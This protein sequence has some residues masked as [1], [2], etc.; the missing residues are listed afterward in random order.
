DSATECER[1]GRGRR[2]A[3]GRGRRAP[4]RRARRRVQPRP[5]RRR[6]PPR[7]P[8]RAGAARDGGGHHG[9]RHRRA[10]RPAERRAG[11]ARPR[12]CQRRE[13]RGAR[14]ARPGAGAAGGGRLHRGG[15]R[16]RQ[17][18]MVR[19]RG[20]AGARDQG[21]RQSGGAG[22]RRRA[23]DR[24]AARGRLVSAARAGAAGAVRRRG[25]R[26][27]RVASAPGRG[28]R[29]RRPRRR[30]SGD[31][32]E[33]PRRR[34]TP[35]VGGRAG[36]HVSGRLRRAAPLARSPRLPRS[37]DL[38]GQGRGAGRAPAF[39]GRLHRRRRGSAGA[40]GRGP[41]PVGR[42]RPGRV[43]PPALALC[44]A[45]R[46]DRHG[47]THGALHHSGGGAPR[48]ARTGARFARGRRAAGRLD[49]TGDRGPPPSLAR[50]ACDRTCWRQSRS[51][52][53]G[54]CGRGAG[55]VPP[56][57]RGPARF[58]GRR[59]AHVPCH[60]FLA[61]VSAGRPAHLERPLHH[62]LRAAGRDRRRAARPRPRGAGLHRRRRAPDGA[63]RVGDGGGARGE[64]RGR[65]VQRRQP[66]AHRHQARRARPPRRRARLAEGGFH[67]GDARLRRFGAARGHRGGVRGGVGPRARGARPGADRRSRRS[68]KLPGA[69]QGAARL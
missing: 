61:G 23:D 27:W 19:P 31:S 45:R 66:L 58:G 21:V 20:H 35:G 47:T 8:L 24:R 6:P 63:G 54:G 69:D 10:V 32:E 43:H 37:R 53:A 29:V 39:R 38:Q 15:A 30:R 59:R 62:G 28:S 12:R 4:L 2:G 11:D 50:A 40:R 64:A 34:E 44:R 55:R 17:P 36:G 3:R 56:G 41:H 57:R 22:H 18:S 65:R 51:F 67:G 49:R 60:Q 46:G 16:L 26:T 1:R 33:A 42:G 48:P 9:L 52:A 14:L 25:A 13:R 68:G 7:P 5:H